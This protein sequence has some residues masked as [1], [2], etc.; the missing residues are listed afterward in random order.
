MRASNGDA[1]VRATP[2]RPRAR[3][4]RNS[5]RHRRDVGKK[6]RRAEPKPRNRHPRRRA[7]KH[8]RTEDTG[9][10]RRRTA[11]IAA[12][13]VAAVAAPCPVRRRRRHLR[14]GGSHFVVRAADDGRAAR[15]ATRAWNGSGHLAY[16]AGEGADGYAGSVAAR[17]SPSRAPGCASGGSEQ[18]R[19]P[20][21]RPARTRAGTTPSCAGSP[22]PLTTLALTSAPPA[23]GCRGAPP[24]F[25]GT[26]ARAPASSTAVVVPRRAQH[27]GELRERSHRAQATGVV[28]THSLVDV[29]ARSSAPVMV[30]PAQPAQGH[31]HQEPGVRAAIAAADGRL[32]RQRM[33]ARSTASPPPR[34]RMRRGK[35]RAPRRRRRR[36]GLGVLLQQGR[37]ARDAPRRVARG[38]ESNG[39]ARRRRHRRP[40]GDATP[41]ASRTPAH[42][43]RRRRRSA[44]RGQL[45]TTSATSASSVS[46]GAGARVSGR[47]RTARHLG[48]A[49]RAPESWGRTFPGRGARAKTPEIWRAPA[50]VGVRGEVRA[51][52]EAAPRRAPRR[53]RLY[54]PAPSPRPGAPRDRSARAAL[55][56]AQ[57]VA[58]TPGAQGAV[59]SPPPAAG[60]RPARRAATHR[61]R[62]RR[63]G[64][65]GAQRLRALQLANGRD[66]AVADVVSETIERRERRRLD[67]DVLRHRPHRDEA[68][69]LSS[70]RAAR[71]SGYVHRVRG[72]T[73]T[74]FGGG[75]AAQ[76]RRFPTDGAKSAVNASASHARAKRPSP[77]ST[78]AASSSSSAASSRRLEPRRLGIGPAFY[79]R[80]ANEPAAASPLHALLLALRRLRLASTKRV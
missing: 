38:G 57:D 76:L 65:T 3:R 77:R 78:S 15:L 42:T 18:A 17:S 47:S 52:P 50:G 35:S 74:G 66:D 69:R 71:G 28:T 70:A 22:I 7:E 26:P 10:R 75:G 39:R 58:Q 36:G 53:R 37:L 20:G 68:R 34:R 25:F 55:Y 33:R 64:V 27:L 16:G 24:I 8:E 79:R 59:A 60:A 67:A 4:S 43:A 61:L 62:P 51:P 49:Q 11:G 73:R 14:G 31:T 54:R 6:M 23:G 13:S 5:D 29:G 30:P 46:R 1:R 12:A 48:Q 2:R 32:L 9:R 56:A 19:P 72:V 40:A 44:R 45:G 41:G 80:H 63:E 21:W